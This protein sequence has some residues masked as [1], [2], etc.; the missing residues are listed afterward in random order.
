MSVKVTG[1]IERKG[2]GPGTWALVGE[3]GQ[4]Y[5]LHKAPDDLKKSGIQVTVE[6]QIREDVMTFAMIG[7]VL[8]VTKFEVKD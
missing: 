2:I 1:K 8:E 4:S 6:G 3:D 7:P 5:E